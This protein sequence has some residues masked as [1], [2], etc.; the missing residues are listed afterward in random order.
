MNLEY[1][2]YRFPFAVPL[3]T[4]QK[5][6]EYREGIFLEYSDDDFSCY[7]E[8]APLP[9][10]SAETLKEVR[11]RISKL[12][13]TIRVQLDADKPVDSL[14]EFYKEE[15]LPASIQFGLDSVAYQIQ[16]HRERKNLQEFL[17]PDAMDR[18]PVNA[19]G[20]LQSEE[21]LQEI[22][23][24]IADGFGTIKFK[25]GMD[26]NAELERL[27]K[28]QSEFP[29]LTIRLDANQSWSTETALRHFQKLES[30][31][32]EY[33]E[34]P[35]QNATPENFELLNEHTQIPLALDE[36]LSRHSYWPNLLPFTSYLIIKPMILGNFTKNFETKR[37]ADTHNNK[38]VFTTSLES[39]VGRHITAILA[40]GLGSPQTAHGL[41]TGNLLTKD[42]DSGLPYISEGFYQLNRYPQSKLDFEKPDDI[43]SISF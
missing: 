22:R 24:H 8:I 28:I 43:S 10:Y 20:S 1:Y 38:A 42:I 5:T 2:K 40:S 23:Q 36:S 12:E 26:F 33:C 30:I 11:K 37:L 19:L 27:Q 18:I 16:A 9:G 15:E 13:E 3:K 35:L 34:E 29:D 41:S 39:G 21:Y 17:F 6:F 4:S 31:D 7:G 25:I 14:Q 32:I